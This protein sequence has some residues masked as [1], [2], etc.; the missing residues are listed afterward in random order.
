MNIENEHTVTFTIPEQFSSQIDS[1]TIR[2]S[3]LF[4]EIVFSRSKSEI[5]VS[6]N[7][8]LAEESIV[9]IRRNVFHQLYKEKVYLDTLSIRK[10]L[11]SDE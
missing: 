2:L 7:K 3:Y 11:Y 5:I 9:E 8:Q 4:P 6:T 10:W 1:A